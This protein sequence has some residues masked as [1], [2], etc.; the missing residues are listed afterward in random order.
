[1]MKR[2]SY[3]TRF[4]GDLFSAVVTRTNTQKLSCQGRPP[5]SVVAVDVGQAEGRDRG[6]WG[7]GSPEPLMTRHSDSVME[8]R[9]MLS[10]LGHF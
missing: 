4:W 5:R 6:L 3:T 7:P 10:F 1:M 2:W 9:R 8:T